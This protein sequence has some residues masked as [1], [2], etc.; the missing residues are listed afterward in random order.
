VKPIYTQHIPLAVSSLNQQPTGV[1][2][3]TDGLDQGYAPWLTSTG[4]LT[5]NLELTDIITMDN[6]KTMSV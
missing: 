4:N 3:G 6:A 5:A 2:A 1:Q